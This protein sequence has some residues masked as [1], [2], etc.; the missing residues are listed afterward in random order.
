M[1][2]LKQKWLHIY[3]IMHLINLN[4]W[5]K[6]TGQSNN[7]MSL[8][9]ET[10]LFYETMTALQNIDYIL[11]YGSGRWNIYA[12]LNWLLPLRKIRTFRLIHQSSKNLQ[13]RCVSWKFPHLKIWWNFRL[14]RIVDSHMGEIIWATKNRKCHE[15]SDVYLPS[16][17]AACILQATALEGLIN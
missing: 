8:E 11:L 5:W 1:Y 15:D 2:K 16:T 10:L 9:L 6:K 7:E 14:L 4:L 12:K 13:K 17:Y 3:M